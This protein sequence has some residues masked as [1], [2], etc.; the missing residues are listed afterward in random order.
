MIRGR[1]IATLATSLVLL[2]LADC[3]RQAFVPAGPEPPASLTIII[4]ESPNGGLTTSFSS[5]WLAQTNPF[6]SVDTVDPG[7]TQAW[8]QAAIQ[9]PAYGEF[10]FPT[11]S[12][13]QVG[14][15]TVQV[16]NS[17]GVTSIGNSGPFNFELYS[18][19]NTTIICTEQLNA[20]GQPGLTCATAYGG[21][22]PKW[23][24]P[25]R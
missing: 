24:P 4:K 18:G 11:M 2:L 8:E 15:W 13:L 3:G 20:Q 12:G 5:L 23:P 17:V 1:H 21:A 19:A 7:A 25:K 6:P 16:V 14:S 9:M 22:R 10:D